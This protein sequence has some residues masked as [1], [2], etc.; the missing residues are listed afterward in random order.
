MLQINSAEAIV[1]PEADAWW[2][3]QIRLYF[4]T[5][6]K[7][8]V[9]GAMAFFSVA[10]LTGSISKAIAV[11]LLCFTASLFSTWR[12]LLEPLAFWSCVI[13]IV[14]WCEPSLLLK[15]KAAITATLA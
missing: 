9:I 8:P 11:C 7:A 10:T 3:D 14:A 1:D 13:A 5:T 6:C 2:D 15:A 12:R 4:R